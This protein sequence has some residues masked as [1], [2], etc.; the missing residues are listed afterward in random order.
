MEVVVAQVTEVVEVAHHIF[1]DIKDVF[2][3]FPM[4]A[5]KA[6]S[7]LQMIQF[8]ILTY[9]SLKQLFLEETN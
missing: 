6:N 1:Q 4:Q 8:T 5:M 7:N 2:Q 9:I 3:F